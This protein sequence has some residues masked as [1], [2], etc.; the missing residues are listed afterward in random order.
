MFL[1][2]KMMPY[3][4]LDSSSNA[5]PARYSPPSLAAAP[6]SSSASTRCPSPPNRPSPTPEALVRSHGGRLAR[7][8][9]VVATLSRRPAGG[10]AC[11]ELVSAGRYTFGSVEG[12]GRGPLGAKFAK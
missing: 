6:A 10:T 3:T 5:R 7:S 2:L 12:P 1:R 4:S 9:T 11:P 8:D